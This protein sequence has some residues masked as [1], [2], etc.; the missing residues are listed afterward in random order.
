MEY[1]G[2]WGLTDKRLLCHMLGKKI[3][4]FPSQSQVFNV[5]DII[6]SFI[7]G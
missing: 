4:L 1:F 7:N 6:Y 2:D 5:I 3:E